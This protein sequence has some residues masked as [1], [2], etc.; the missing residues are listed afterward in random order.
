MGE[1]SLLL[2]RISLCTCVGSNQTSGRSL[3]FEPYLHGTRPSSARHAAAHVHVRQSAENLAWN[4]SADAARVG[5]NATQGH[6]Q[7]SAHWRQEQGAS[8]TH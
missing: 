2:C 6:V 7:Q 8:T 3:G 4:H 5:P 1:V